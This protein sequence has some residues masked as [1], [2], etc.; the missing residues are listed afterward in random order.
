MRSVFLLLG[1]MLCSYLLHAQQTITGKIVDPKTGAPVADVSV[2]NKSTK[3]GTATNIDGVFKIVASVNDK[4]E[5]SSVG[6]KTQTVTVSGF[7]DLSISL[8]ASTAELSEVVFVG[9]RGA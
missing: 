8:D 2:R 9:N 4:L 3:I 7:S 5:I 1:I 6:F